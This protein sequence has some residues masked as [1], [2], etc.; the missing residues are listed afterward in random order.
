MKNFL[1]TTAFA[2]TAATGFTSAAMADGHAACGEVSITEM[3]W[4]SAAIVTS[5]SAFLM[6]QGYG[7]DVTKIPSST[8]PALASVSETGKPDIV[9]ELWING[10][11]SY[12]KLTE[13]GTITTLTDVLSDG[14]IEGW[15]IPKY[16]VD[17]HPEL[18]TLE[19]LLAN[20]ELVDSRFHQCPEG[21]GCMNVN[22]SLAAA[23]D[24]E[25]N[26]FEVFKHGS[27][28]TMA[29]SIA[30]AFEAKEPW[31]GYYWAPTS[32]L[33]KYEMVSVDLG[34][35]N[36]EIH[37]CN[38]DP[39]CEEAGLSS[40]PVGPVKTIVTTDFVERHPDLAE[41]MTN[42]SFTNAQMGEVLAWQ[43]DNNASA[44]EAAVYF[45]TTYQDTWK[46]WVNDAASEKLAA[47]LQ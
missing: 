1:I 7:C 14:G 40:Y 17:E 6:E 35:Y 11:P 39:D 8:T 36:E 18:A 31:L 2:A 16:V 30:A 10:A 47:L 26:G 5:I 9:T 15:W 21:W 20:P 45:L 24:L 22:A 19:G 32:V 27:G 33:G 37:L 34:E 42:V 41:L 3:N 28:E 25:G 43:E 29:T 44:D 23:V 46:D 38:A 13:A 12:D 4:A